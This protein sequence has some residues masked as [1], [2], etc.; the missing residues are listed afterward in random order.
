MSIFKEIQTHIF[1][2]SIRV[3]EIHQVGDWFISAT[4]KLTAS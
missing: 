4:I 1:L 3:N 2:F